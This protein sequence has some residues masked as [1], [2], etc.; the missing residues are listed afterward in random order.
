MSRPTDPI[1]IISPPPPP[2]TTSASATLTSEE[3]NMI[4][5]GTSVL[6]AKSFNSIDTAIAYLNSLKD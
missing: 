6:Q 5:S 1:I 4:R 2:P 3:W